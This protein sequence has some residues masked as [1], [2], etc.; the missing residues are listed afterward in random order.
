MTDH[1]VVIR[2]D[3][4]L[5]AYGLGL[6]RV[7]TL[8]QHGMGSVAEVESLPEPLRPSGMEF[9]LPSPIKT[10]PQLQKEFETWV[11]GNGLQE[12]VDLLNRLL[13][14]ARIVLAAL[15]CSSGG[16]RIP[17]EEWD[18]AVERPK[19]GFHRAGLPQKLEYLEAHFGPDV[20]P[21]S[22]EAVLS[23]NRVRNCLVHRGGIV[24]E[25]ELD[26]TDV[27]RVHWYRLHLV[28]EDREGSRRDREVPAAFPAGSTLKVSSSEVA[29]TFYLGEPIEV[30][31]ED[32]E[33]FAWT[34]S[35][36]GTVLAANVRAF[37]DRMNVPDR[38]PGLNTVEQ[39]GPVGL[40]TEGEE[41]P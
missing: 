38:E 40:K 39:G 10:A 28:I 32:F 18:A 1:H 35:Q 22:T 19:K 33:G 37:G 26:G 17:V 6:G 27:L 34:F 21:D 15:L 31:A 25:R 30:R 29:R 12:M 23:L 16:R 5:P 9:H 14:D 4:L 36:F 3:Q 7:V 24:G 2:L 8:V 11:V 41:P 20:L 13:E